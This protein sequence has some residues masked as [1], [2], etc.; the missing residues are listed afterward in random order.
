MQSFKAKTAVTQNR[1]DTSK[2]FLSQSMQSKQV[3][4]SGKVINDLKRAEY[5]K[6]LQIQKIQQQMKA[7]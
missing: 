1:L 6:Q 5:L 2:Q 7:K 4:T 3:K